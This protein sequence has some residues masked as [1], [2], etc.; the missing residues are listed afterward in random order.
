MG[1]N[2]GVG[3]IPEVRNQGKRQKRNTEREQCS[4]MEKAFSLF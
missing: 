4:C 1:R 2:F 3:K